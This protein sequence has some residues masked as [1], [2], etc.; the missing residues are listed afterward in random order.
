M[1]T[2]VT[3]YVKEKKSNFRLELQMNSYFLIYN[4]DLVNLFAKLIAAENYPTP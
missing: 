3:S 4:M 1:K 2:K